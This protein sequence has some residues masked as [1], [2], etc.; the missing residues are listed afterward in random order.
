MCY[1]LLPFVLSVILC[2]TKLPTNLHTFSANGTRDDARSTSSK[3]SVFSSDR[4]V[5]LEQ[6]SDYVQVVILCIRKLPMNLH[7]HSGMG[8]IRQSSL[9]IIYWFSSG[10]V[11]WLGA[12]LGMWHL[13]I[14]K[15]T[16]VHERGQELRSCYHTVSLSTFPNDLIL[17]MGTEDA[18]VEAGWEHR[19]TATATNHSFVS[20][21]KK[22][23]KAPKK[24]FGYHC[25]LLSGTRLGFHYKVRACTHAESDRRWRLQLALQIR[26]PQF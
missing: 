18:V 20:K 23:L 8:K 10:C 14:Q 21:K 6:L 17:E 19:A 12:S 3:L 25:R 15:F 16:P 2:T 13:V 26:Y 4:V 5:R 24:A 11:P 7:A 9:P 1:I 22:R